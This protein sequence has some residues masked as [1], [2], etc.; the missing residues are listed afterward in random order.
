MV[1]ISSKPLGDRGEMGIERER[2]RK[3]EE[4]K[5]GRLT[6]V[7]RSARSARAGVGIFTERRSSIL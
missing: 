1:P 5:G 7:S 4:R 3:R 2:G 6:S